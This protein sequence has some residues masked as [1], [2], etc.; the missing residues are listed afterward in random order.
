M[1]DTT[2]DPALGGAGL[3]AHFYRRDVLGSLPNS[4][5]RAA[6]QAPPDA[7]ASG[8]DASLIQRLALREM[9]HTL[10]GWATLAATATATR[11]A[12]EV[13]EVLRGARKTLLVALDEAKALVEIESDDAPARP[14]SEAA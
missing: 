5:P 14:E 9:A 3:E 10:C 7:A 8:N 6:L 1:E 2:K 11:P 4:S 12:P 13:L